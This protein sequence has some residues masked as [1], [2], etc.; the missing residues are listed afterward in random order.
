MA[1]RSPAVAGSFYSAD[2]D[3]LRQDLKSLL[4]GRKPPAEPRGIALLAPHAGYF[5]S[6]GVA[7]DVYTS[8]RL[9]S[10]V[11][12]L[13]PNHSGRGQPI[14]IMADG[15]W[16]MPLGDV[17]I[18]V[19]LALEI[20]SR[21]RAAREDDGAHTSEHSLEV[22]VPFLQELVPGARIVP[23][24]VGTMHL[25]TLLDLGNAVAGAISGSGEEV[26]VVISSDMSHYIPAREAEVMDHKAIDK[27]LAIDPS[28]LHRIVLE[29]EISMC[30][31]APAVAGLE[32]ARCLGARTARLISYA[33]SGDRS[34]DYRSVVGYAGIAIT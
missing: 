14:A 26:L 21:C 29:E 24:C 34:G 32:T 3:K 6:G 15:V 19:S 20:L 7:A 1:S 8:V 30:G 27:V 5:Y 22:Q 9:A 23:V 31:A 12:I 10:R 11:V 16:R 28:G 18:D 33:N 25:P 13:G 4:A 17:P 2:P